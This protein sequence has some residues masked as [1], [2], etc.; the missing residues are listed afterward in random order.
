MQLSSRITMRDNFPPKIVEILKKRAAFVCSNPTCKKMTVAPSELEDEKV[1]YI[2]RAAH[3]CAA[4]EKGPRFDITMTAE[5]R[6]SINNAIF[7]CSNCADMIDDNGGADYSV[8]KL[9]KWKLDHENWT[10]DNLNKSIVT[11]NSSPTIF[12][13]TSQNQTGGITAGIVNFAPVGRHLN[14]SLK[15]QLDETF[16]DSSEKIKISAQMS[17]SE[18]NDFAEEIKDYLVGKGFQIIEIAQFMQSPPII[19]QVLSTDR[20]GTRHIKIGRKPK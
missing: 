1:L 9:K 4:S 19:G 12:N 20:D 16:P 3:I 5:D 15:K 11:N 18:A 10:R 13:V 17:D 7:L 6:A 2:G 8:D 14:E